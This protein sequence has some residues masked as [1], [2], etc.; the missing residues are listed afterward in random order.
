MAADDDDDDGDDDAD[1]DDDGDGDDDERLLR[2][3]EVLLLLT[4]SADDDDDDD[5]ADNDDGDDADDDDGGGGGGFGRSLDVPQRSIM[6]GGYRFAFI[7][8]LIRRTS[9]VYLGDLPQ[10][11][12]TVRTLTSFLSICSMTSSN[13][14]GSL[15]I[16]A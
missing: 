14:V 11:S 12:I 2:R 16:I 10:S 7:Q 3:G 15:S 13:C 6:R 5:D 8:Q 9:T 4:P 1:A